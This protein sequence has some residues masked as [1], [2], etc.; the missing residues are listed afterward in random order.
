V[1]LDEFAPV[2]KAADRGDLLNEVVGIAQRL[3]FE[4]VSAMVVVDS[5][6]GE[7]EFLCVN[8]TPVE[9]G[10]VANSK[11][12]ARRDPVMQHCKRNSIPIIWNRDT[13]IA[14]GRVEQ[15]EIQAQFGYFAG[16]ALALHLPEGRHFFIGVDRDRPLPSNPNEVAR[17]VAHLQL[18]AAHAQDAALRILAPP[19]PLPMT[20]ALTARELE[21]LRWTMDGKTAWEV[22]AILKISEQ[23][24]ARHLSNATRKLGCVNK[25]QAVVKALRLGLMR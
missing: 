25:V 5:L 3:G 22:G 4:K 19:S 18:F 15:W 12:V 21:A 16:I 6:H 20:P 14:A 17:R 2:T 24:A 10:E 9:L 13:Y 23:T 7:P 8:N 1:R 11:D